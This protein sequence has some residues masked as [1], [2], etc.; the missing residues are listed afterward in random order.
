MQFVDW[1]GSYIPIFHFLVVK[2]AITLVLTVLTIV[3]VPPAIILVLPAPYILRL[4]RRIGKW[5]A[6]IA[7]EGLSR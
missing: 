7:I 1:E 3:V 4:F 2:S 5:Q 6:D